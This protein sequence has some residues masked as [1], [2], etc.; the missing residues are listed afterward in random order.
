MNKILL[1]TLS[2]LGDAVLS[3]P[4]A[5]TLRKNFN[6]AKLDVAV[7]P[8]ASEVFIRDPRINKV[9]IYRKDSTLREKIKFIRLLRNE[10]YDLV[11]DLRNTII[12]FLIHPR[13]QAP[14]PFSR[15]PKQNLYKKE[16]HLWKLR[17]L[18]LKV[19][20]EFD[21]YISKEDEEIINKKL[22]NCGIKPTDILIGIAPGSK[23]LIKRW[24]K[25]GFMEVCR[26][27]TLEDNVQIILIGNENDKPIAKD[28]RDS[29]QNNII[30]WT[31]STT[32]GELVSLIK[33]LK[34]LI[35][36]DSAP[37]HISVAVGTPVVAIFGPT[38]PKE[39][40]PRGEQDIIIRKDLKCSP[41]KKAVCKYNLECMKGI[42]PDE[43]VKAARKIL[44]DRL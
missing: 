42:S 15:F 34:L 38:D 1:I 44:Y 5:E 41:C 39:Y 24:K 31:G 9:Y 2:N 36:N 7:G 35:S 43:V 10:K 13:Y 23:S 14:G 27:L 3:L 17:P 33:R 32:F 25:E 22:C 11:V 30:D 29:I 18:G 26:R 8:N 4:V 28:I 16:E 21:I 37:M 6:T 20:G 19:S 40:G 12:P